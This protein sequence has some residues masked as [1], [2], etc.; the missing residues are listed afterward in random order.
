MAVLA[1][2]GVVLHAHLHALRTQRRHLEGLDAP[3]VLLEHRL[4]V[5]LVH[6][7]PAPEHLHLELERHLVLVL[8]DE[9]VLDVLRGLDD[10][11]PQDPGRADGLQVLVEVV[12]GVLVPAVRAKGTRDVDLVA[13]GGAR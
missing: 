12:N 11:L 13:G 7:G 9:H 2:L 5:E 3:Q 6:G 8:H 10:E 4:S 1:E